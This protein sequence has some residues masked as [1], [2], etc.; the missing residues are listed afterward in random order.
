[1][2]IIVSSG[3]GGPRDIIRSPVDFADFENIATTSQPPW[4]IASLSSGT[5]VA[6]AAGAVTRNHPGVGRCTSSATANSGVRITTDAGQILL[7][8]GEI[9]VCGFQIITL[10]TVTVRLGFH[11]TQSSIDAADG[12]YFEFNG[13]NIV[14]KTANNNTRSTTGTSFAPSINT[15]Y[16]ARIELNS[17]ATLV[18]FTLFNESGSTVLLSD[19]LGTNI[20]TAT[21]RETG[22][23]FVATSSGTTSI[24][25][26]HLDYLGRYYASALQ[27]S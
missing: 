10:A 7:G 17:N 25:L 8:G 6:A 22:H 1:M 26:A 12:A 4:T 20:P 2:G 13:T 15:W 3:G 16:G 21:G 5:F 23:G 9:F 24:S 11:D 14:G 18:T 19:T 27:R